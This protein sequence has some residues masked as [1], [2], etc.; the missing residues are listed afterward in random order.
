MRYYPIHLDIKDRLALVV[1]GG[2]VAEG[3]AAQLLDAGARVR[4]V[5]P[6]LTAGLDDLLASGRIEHRA[7]LFSEDDLEGV[8][9]V[10]SATDDREA[11][12]A[13][14]R[15]A[16]SRS[17]W[18][19]VVDDPR[20]CDFITPA[21]VV[22]GE[23]QIGISTAGKSPVLAQRVKREIGELIGDEYGEL[24]ELAAAMR[25]RAKRSIPDFSKR[26]DLLRAFV[27][28]EAIDLLRRGERDAAERIAERLLEERR[29]EN[30]TQRERDCAARA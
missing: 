1:G 27:E 3:K 11:N 9:L 18:C 26:R 16:R 19:N 17:I 23:L 5:S 24:L 13:V 8:S 29:E 12:E 7:A 21:L 25:E 28:S 4:V 2:A 14:A 10:I 22:R 30:E 15:A 20:L 6:T